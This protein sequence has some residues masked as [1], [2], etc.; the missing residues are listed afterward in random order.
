MGL[1]DIFSSGNEKKAARAQQA[2]LRR[3]RDAAYGFID[4]GQ[5][6]YDDYAFQ[7]MGQFDTYDTIG[8]QGATTY[9]DALGLNGA[10]AAG[11][12]RD[13]F[14]TSAGYDFTR[15]EALGATERLGSKYG[16]NGSGNLAT[17]LQDRASGLASQESNNWLNRLQGLTDT[18]VGVAGARAGILSGQGANAQN[19][20]TTKGQIG[21]NTEAGVGNA[22]A[23]YQMSKDNSGMNFL[24]AVTGLLAL[25]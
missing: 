2:G 11:A 16:W 21:W 17:A 20:G 23:Q 6:G 3:G 24:N 9:A 19:V 12:A 8:R 1:F 18:G 15:D 22:E 13:A 14:T 7:A 10:G 5:E 4:E 25:R